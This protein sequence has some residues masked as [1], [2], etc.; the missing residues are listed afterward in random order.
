MTKVQRG[1]APFLFPS[2]CWASCWNLNKNPSG[3]EFVLRKYWGRVCVWRVWRKKVV[4]V[5]GWVWACVCV[6]L[7]VGVGWG[8]G[9]YLHTH[10]CENVWM[11][12]YACGCICLCVGMCACT[13]V[14]ASM[15]CVWVIACMCVCVPCVCLGEHVCLCAVGG[16]GSISSASGGAVR[17]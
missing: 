16:R 14:D 15:W 6:H 1:Q 11:C 2:E 9:V 10:G 3:W 8:G 13:H 12:V 17:T 4:Y 7:C 5:C